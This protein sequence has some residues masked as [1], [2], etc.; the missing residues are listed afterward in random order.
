MAVDIR[1]NQAVSAL[2][3]RINDIQS[4]VV[5]NASF[6]SAEV[7]LVRLK[8]NESLA[9]IFGTGSDICRNGE[10]SCLFDAMLFYNANTWAERQ[11]IF[12]ASLPLAQTKIKFL[13]RKILDR[14]AA[15][16]AATLLK[17]QAFSSGDSAAA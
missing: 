12:Q 2:R 14:S 7:H 15:T 16:S 11:L 17:S 10:Y 13:I 4:L 5:A 1:V 6:D 3:S 9:E 8:I